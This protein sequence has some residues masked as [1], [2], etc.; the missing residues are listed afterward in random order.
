MPA[1]TL[2]PTAQAA[3]AVWSAPGLLGRCC[4]YSATGDPATKSANTSALDM[5]NS[6]IAAGIRQP[7]ATDRPMRDRLPV[8]RGFYGARRARSCE[9]ER[10]EAH[11]VAPSQFR[12]KALLIA[13]A[14][15]T[16]DNGRRKEGARDGFRNRFRRPHRWRWR[17]R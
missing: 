13:A 7:Q 5:V 15:Q 4:A 12:G 3:A 17:V 16:S 14:R 8:S 2:R 9:P 11:Q 1:R 6:L 10:P